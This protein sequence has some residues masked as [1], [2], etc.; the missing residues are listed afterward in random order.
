MDAQIGLTNGFKGLNKYQNSYEKVYGRGQKPRYSRKSALNKIF[1][2]NLD[3]KK[4]KNF[5]R[6]QSLHR[7]LGKINKGDL[8]WGIERTNSSLRLKTKMQI[9]KRDLNKCFTRNSAV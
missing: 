6:N 8:N 1:S 5:A 2:P 3:F 4:S 7:S 9:L